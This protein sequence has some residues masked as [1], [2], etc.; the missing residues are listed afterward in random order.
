MPCS[1]ASEH[2]YER[3]RSCATNSVTKHR[4]VSACVQVSEHEE[5]VGGCKS[6]CKRASKH[7]IFQREHECVCAGHLAT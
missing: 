4:C 3:A 6:A 5:G 1:C 2:A 7:A